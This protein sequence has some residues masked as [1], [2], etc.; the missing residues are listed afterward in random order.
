MPQ[1][2]AVFGPTARKL[3]NPA[4]E[5]RWTEYG[6]GRHFPAMEAPEVPAADLRTFFGGLK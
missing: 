4:A 6:R 1:A 3:I 5:V 2:F